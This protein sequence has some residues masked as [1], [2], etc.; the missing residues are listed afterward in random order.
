EN[1]VPWGRLFEEYQAMFSL[2]ESDL[3]GR[4]LGCGDGP[5]GF[6][7]EATRRGFAVTSC[8]PIYQFNA[9]QIRARVTEIYPEMNRQLAQNLDGFVWTYFKAPEEV[10][11]T[12]LKA[13]EVFLE[14]FET[15]LEQGRYQVASL[16]TLPFED[17]SFDLALCSHFLFLYSDQFDSQF[18]LD[19]VLELCRVAR[20][21]RIFPLLAL[22]SKPSPHLDYVM[23]QAQQRGYEVTLERVN[24]EFQRGGHTMLKVKRG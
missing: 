18:H 12:R 3:A 1:V 23:E 2:T 10:S 6:N 5:A 9:A 7:A 4:I 13:M 8:D 15:G 17:H 22:G 19:S 14:D 20:E 21:V 11:A 24:Y 16:P